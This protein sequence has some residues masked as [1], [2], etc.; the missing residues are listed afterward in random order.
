MTFIKLLFRVI[1]R[2]LCLGELRFSVIQLGKRTAKLFLRVGNLNRAVVQFNLRVG[3]LFLAVLDFLFAILELGFG[4]VQLLLSVNLALRQILFTVNDFLLRVTKNLVI[5]DNTALFS[6]FCK[7]IGERFAVIFVLLGIAR[8]RA[9]SFRVNINFR[10]IIRGKIALGHYHKRVKRAVTNCGAS[11]LA[12]RN[13]HRR[14]V[15]PD[16]RV[17]RPFKRELFRLGQ[18]NKRYRIADIYALVKHIAADE[19]LALVFNIAALENNGRVH[20]VGEFGINSREELL[21]AA[22]NRQIRVL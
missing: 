2:F 8:H 13:V 4:V 9:Q 18:I 3:E 7:F 5:A 15:P 19:T 10:V 12:H 22:L 11:A 20:T 1:K 16:N 17:L 6:E 21:V 14:V